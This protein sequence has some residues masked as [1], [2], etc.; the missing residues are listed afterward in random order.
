[1]PGVIDKNISLFIESQFPNIYKEN[2]EELVALTR[3]YYK[4]M[5]TTNNQ[6]IYNARRIFEYRDIAETSTSML[7]YFKNKFMADMPLDESTV[8]VLV[9]NITDLYQRKGTPQGIELFFRMFYNEDVEVK[10]PASQMLKVSGSNWKTGNYLQMYPNTNQFT[11]DTGKTYSYADLLSRNITGSFSGA[12]AAVDKI[13][14]ILLNGEYVPIIYIDEVKG[15]FQKFDKLITKV[16]GEQ[17]SFGFVD[18]SLNK[19]EILEETTVGNL[20]GDIVD[21]VSGGGV[22]GKA[23]V[24]EIT[25]DIDGQVKFNLK[26]GGW[27]YTA[28]GTRLLLSNQVIVLSNPAQ[29]F[30]LYERLTD[31]NGSSGIVVDQTPVQLAVRIDTGT[32]FSLN[33]VISTVDRAS[34]INLSPSSVTAKNTSAP[35][36][37]FPDTGLNTD[38]KVS[39]LSNEETVNL[40]ADPIA[41]YLGVVLNQA[42]YGAGT[43]MS[44]TASPVNITTPLEDA[45]A[46]TEYTLGTILD[47]ENLNPGT[48]YLNDVYAAVQDDSFSIFDKRDQFINFSL[49]TDVFDFTAG[50]ILTETNTGYTGIIKEVNANGYLVITPY[51]YYGFDSITNDVL[52]AGVIEYSTES[53]STNYD[54]LPLGENAEMETTVAFEIGAIKSAAVYNSGFGYPNGTEANLVDSTGLVRAVAEITSVTQGTNSGYWSSF[55]SHINGYLGKENQTAGNFVLNTYYTIISAGDTDF[56]LIGALDSNPGTKFTATGKG[57]GT[58]VASYDAYYDSKK[59]V[60]DS[61]YFQEYSYELKSM[62]NPKEYIPNLQDSVHLAGSK[63]FNQFLFKAKTGTELKNRFIRFFND[64]GRGS[65]LDTQPLNQITVDILNFTVD[66]TEA[67]VDNIPSI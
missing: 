8:R 11:S 67:T 21:V 54:S 51:T 61:D 18:G 15:E 9:R 42:D 20:I 46:L 34:N 60:Q 17:V 36:N 45:F 48:Q 24:T 4:W 63:I 27:G 32:E 59:R 57:L 58:G 1:M 12:K 19:L 50:E 43:P 52:R 39:G 56:T 16:N 28:A 5:E 64:D 30:V 29:D 25:T 38:V 3:E 44:G 35:G 26:D 47:F 41:P 33:Y 22:G 40:I 49:P 6:S 62:V 14:T 31:T 66:S 37:L 53:S 55:D 7:I 10:Y 2:G 65:I 23:I 13:N